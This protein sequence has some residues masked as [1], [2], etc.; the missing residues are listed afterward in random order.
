MTWEDERGE[1]LDRITS[2]EKAVAAQEE[3]AKGLDYRLAY[4]QERVDGIYGKI[5]G[6]MMM[7][8]SRPSWLMSG[9]FALIAALVS[10]LLVYALK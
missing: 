3:R 2:L 8:Y 1:V 6:L 10:G 7:Q 5:D 4:I 9:V